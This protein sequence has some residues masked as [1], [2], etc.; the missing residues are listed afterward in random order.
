MHRLAQRMPVPPAIVLV[1]GRTQRRG[2]GLPARSWMQKR[3]DWLL[4]LSSQSHSIAPETLHPRRLFLWGCRILLRVGRVQ[5]KLR[6]CLRRTRSDYT[7]QGTDLR[8]AN[9][10]FP[11][12]APA[13]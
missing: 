3:G 5:V 12:S 7:A 4:V 10:G 2:T 1:F 6:I 9:S 13:T 11:I 8:H